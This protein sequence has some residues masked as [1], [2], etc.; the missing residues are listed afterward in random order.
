MALALALAVTS[1]VASSDIAPT[2]WPYSFS[3]PFQSNLSWSAPFH[4]VGIDGALRYDYSLRAQRVDHS[5]GALECLHFYNSP[6]GCS[7]LMLADGM[8]RMLP[9]PQPPGQPACCLDMPSIHAPPPAWANASGRTDALRVKIPYA[10]GSEAAAVGWQYPFTGKCTSRLQGTDSGCHS[11]YEVAGNTHDNNDADAQW[12]PPTTT[13]S[14]T[15]GL[16]RLFTFP[17]H[18][19]RQDWYFDPTSLKAGPVTGDAF[20]LPEGCAGVQC[21]KSRGSMG[22]AAPPST[23]AVAMR[24][25]SLALLAREKRP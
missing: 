15:A 22:N 19:G 23:E 2:P 14:S 1:T 7:L 11:Y 8:Y 6:N 17:V 18:G 5:A 13:T 25:L 9:S 4:A 3:V 10:Y 16:P 24:M 20:V 21:P 12:L